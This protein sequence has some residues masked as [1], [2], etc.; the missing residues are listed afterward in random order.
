[1]EVYR[2]MTG[3]VSLTGVSHLGYNLNEI[4]IMPLGVKDQSRVNPGAAMRWTT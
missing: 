4:N 2:G 1:M 3:T